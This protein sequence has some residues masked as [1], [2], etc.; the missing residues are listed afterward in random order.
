[1]RSLDTAH[2]FA[3]VTLPY[4]FAVRA[5][6]RTFWE[7]TYLPLWALRQHIDVLH[8]PAGSAPAVR[9]VPCVLTLHDLG[10]EV[11][12]RYRTSVGPRLYFAKVVPWSARFATEVI[13]DSGATKR[14]AMRRLGILDERL[15]VIPLGPA[16]SIRRTPPEAVECVRAKYGLGGQYFLQV[17]SLIPRKNLDGALATWARSNAAWPTSPCCCRRRHAAS[18]DPGRS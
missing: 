13:A 7:Q 15:T 18:L 9:S 11:A 4:A 12:R 1:L 2:E 16:A 14:D 3:A 5:Y 10:D 6:M 8:V 17:G